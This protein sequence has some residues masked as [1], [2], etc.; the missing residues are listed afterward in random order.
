MLDSKINIK[1]KQKP[2]TA[3]KGEYDRS[4]IQITRDLCGV[5]NWAKKEFRAR[6]KWLA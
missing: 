4:V 5:E 3:K 2:F 1:A 6:T